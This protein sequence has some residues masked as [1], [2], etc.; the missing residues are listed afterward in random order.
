MTTPTKSQL[1]SAIAAATLASATVTAQFVAGK[2]TRDALYLTALDVTTLPA[3]VA[4]TSAF[5]IL[6]V[7]VSSRALRRLEPGTFVSFTFLASSLLLFAT[8]GLTIAAPTAAAVAVYLLIS[9]LGPILG[10]GFWLI[11]TERFD[12]RTARVSITRITTGASIGG[13]LGG[14]LSAPLGSVL[15][16][17]PGWTRARPWASK[18]SEISFTSWR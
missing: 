15:S 3:M 6:L 14:L 7:G 5:S 1:N 8:W 4:L 11:A 12:P 17:T 2:A 10:S 13:L 16:L 18:P 9:G